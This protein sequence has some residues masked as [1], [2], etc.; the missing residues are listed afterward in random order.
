MHRRRLLTFPGAGAL[1]LTG[2]VG[3]QLGGPCLPASG[4]SPRPVPAALG[5]ERASAACE[6]SLG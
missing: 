6:R 1:G 2:S 5:L 4:R 3:Q